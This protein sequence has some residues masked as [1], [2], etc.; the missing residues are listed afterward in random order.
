MKER[1][2]VLVLAKIG[3][4]FRVSGLSHIEAWV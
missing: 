1:K 3:I 4:R 2:V